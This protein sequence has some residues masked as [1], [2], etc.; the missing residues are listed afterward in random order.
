MG[1]FATLGTNGTQ[2]VNNMLNVIMLSVAFF[3][4]LLLVIILSLDMLSVVTPFNF[5]YTFPSS[6][7]FL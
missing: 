3:I 1:L 7:F 2:H 4:A 6:I 5:P